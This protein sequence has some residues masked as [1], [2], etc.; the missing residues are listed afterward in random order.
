MELRKDIGAEEFGRLMELYVE[1]F[2]PEERRPLSQMPPADPAFT[3]YAV[4]DD[5]GLL[6]AWR[7][8]DFTYV[9]HFAVYPEL[10]GHGIGSQALAALPGTVLLEVEPPECS[11]QAR[12]RIEFYRR[13][14]FRLLDV[15]Y[16]QPPYSPGLPSVPLRLM[17]RGELE[18]VEVA[19]FMLHSRVYGAAGRHRHS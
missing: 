16:V 10:R 1:A 6:T 18:D 4:G 12:R 14:G 17:V 7:F 5:A 8:P 3:F 15:D 2:P 13:N 9:E 19:V 11:E